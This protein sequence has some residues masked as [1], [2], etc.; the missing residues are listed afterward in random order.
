MRRVSYPLN[1]VISKILFP[2]CQSIFFDR[3]T[4]LVFNKQYMHICIV[5]WIKMIKFQD[6]P[7]LTK[8]VT[9]LFPTGY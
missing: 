3:D 7:L 9:K 4:G 5:L 2:K 6:I 1:C 8:R